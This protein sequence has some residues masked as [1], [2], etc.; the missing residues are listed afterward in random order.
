MLPADCV[1][2]RPREVVTAPASLPSESGPWFAAAYDGA[3]TYCGEDIEPGD[4]IR[5]DG[6]GGWLG[7]CCG[8][9]NAPARPSRFISVHGLVIG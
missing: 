7:R 3:C 1:D 9:D 5:A 6:H 8:G 4:D 2:C